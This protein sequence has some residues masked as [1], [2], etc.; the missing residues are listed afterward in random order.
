MLEKIMYLIMC[1]GFIIVIHTIFKFFELENK[2]IHLIFLKNL[3]IVGAISFTLYKLFL[4]QIF[5]TE[6]GQTVVK[7]SA[8]VIAVAT[9]AAQKTLSNVISGISL[10]ASHPYDIGQKIQVIS[11][12]G[13]VISEGIVKTITLRHT[14]ISQYN[15]KN[16][17]V[18]N[19]IMDSSTIV[20]TNFT[21]DVGNYLDIEISY[22]AD[23]EKARKIIEKIIQSTPKVLNSKEGQIL[24][25]GFGENGILLRT[26][27]WTRN[28]DDNYI[29]C[30]QIRE[31][32]LKQFKKNHIEIPYQTIIV[33]TTKKKG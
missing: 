29:A 7:S 16:D 30:S 5:S 6:I 14:I 11:Q 32:I 19:S 15:G 28:L 27:V 21:D 4:V 1:A 20:N 22:E 17:I 33:N 8:F 24:I 26:T 23:I 25:R 31:N 12:N 2:R 13:N 18:P 10:S 9:L 3:L